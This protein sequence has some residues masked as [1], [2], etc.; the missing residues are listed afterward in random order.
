MSHLPM[1]AITITKTIE[2]HVTTLTLEI[3]LD[4]VAITVFFTTTNSFKGGYFP[5]YL[6]YCKKYECDL[7]TMVIGWWNT[8]LLSVIQDYQV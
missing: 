8:S 6:L 4:I 1:A 3:G 7:I 5:R 2:H